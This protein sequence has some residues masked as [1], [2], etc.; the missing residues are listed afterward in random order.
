MTQ[1]K[2]SRGTF[3]PLSII[4]RLNTAIHPLEQNGP[5]VIL[6]GIFRSKSIK[7]ALDLDSLILDSDR[8]FM[9]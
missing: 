5:G 1:F 6:E 3:D 8:F 7:S 4:Y 2:M 9:M